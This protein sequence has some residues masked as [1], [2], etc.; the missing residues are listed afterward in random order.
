MSK[1][2]KQSD[3]VGSTYILEQVELEPFVGVRSEVLDCSAVIGGDR[4][5][6][7]E[8]A[9]RL[10]RRCASSLPPPIVPWT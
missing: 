3:A 4:R 9:Q 8:S 5:L 7:A 1:T 10:V 2:L 6:S